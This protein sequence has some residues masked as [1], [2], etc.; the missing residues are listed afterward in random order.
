MHLYIDYY[1]KNLPEANMM[2]FYKHLGV[3]FTH[4]QVFSYITTNHIVSRPLYRNAESRSYVSSRSKFIY[5][6]LAHR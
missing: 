2:W 5:I 3:Y 6:P 4:S 1:F